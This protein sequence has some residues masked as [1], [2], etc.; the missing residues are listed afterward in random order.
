MATS[1]PLEIVQSY[2]DLLIMQYLNKTNASATTRLLSSPPIM[3][4]TTVQEILFTPPPT[5]GSFVLSYGGESSASISWDSDAAAIQVILRALTGLS[6]VT[7]TG[8]ILS[9]LS[10]TFTNVAA[11]GDLLVLVSSTLRTITATTEITIA[12]TDVTLPIAVENGFNLIPGT[13]LAVGVQ[14][15]TLAKYVGVTRDGPGFSQPISLSDADFISLIRM[16]I[17][18]NYSG[19]SL[20]TIQ[21]FLFEFFPG[22]IYVFDYANMTMTYIMSQAVGSQELA[23]LFVTEGILPQPMAVRVSVFYVPTTNLFS[24][25]TYEHES[26]NGEPFNNYN[27]YV[28]TWPWLTYGYLVA[29]GSTIYYSPLTLYFSFR[30]Y[31]TPSTL[32][33]FN[34]YSVYQTIWPFKTY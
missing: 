9:S 8:T 15:D 7:V 27:T 29:I 4:Q 20:A 21:Q 34:N 2:V 13:D 33:P 10:V 6:A 31:G 5:S 26:V 1:T 25:R 22:Q 32:A 30:T 23:Q 12:E 3:P 18:K 16:G 19:S 17:F 11:P 24:F 28:T 14:L